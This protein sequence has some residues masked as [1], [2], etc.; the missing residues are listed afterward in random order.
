[1][2]INQ[3]ISQAVAWAKQ[4]PVVMFSLGLAAQNRLLILHY[5]VLGILKVPL[6]RRI[7]LGNPTEVLASIDAFRKEVSDDLAEA[8]KA[9]A[10]PA[11]S[12]VAPQPQPSAPPVQP[13]R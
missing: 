4:N 5:A 9:D 3:A 6:L 8:A 12:P 11:S 7:A 2:D 1:M 13:G 10:A